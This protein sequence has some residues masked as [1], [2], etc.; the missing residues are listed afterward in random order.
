MKNT[1]LSISYQLLQTSAL[2]WSPVATLRSES[3]IAFNMI[4]TGKEYSRVRE[5]WDG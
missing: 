1:R 5:G 4:D 3:H 2:C